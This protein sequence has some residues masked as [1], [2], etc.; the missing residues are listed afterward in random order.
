[1]SKYSIKKIDDVYY[2]VIKQK[3]TKTVVQC[4]ITKEMWGIMN[5]RYNGSP[6]RKI[7][8][9]DLNKNIKQ[10][11]QILN[12]NELIEI[13]IT[14]GGKEKKELIPKFKLIH[15]HTARRSFCSNMYKKKMPIYDIMH[16]SGHK[17][18]KEFY[19]YIR[20]Y[21]EERASYIVKQGFFNV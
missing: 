2:F 1:M 15:S 21:G 9:Q 20:I 18:E 7:L 14:K 16:F 17:T 11:G 3:K 8:E 6:P 12:F 13:S 5:I 10:V 4:P 19:K